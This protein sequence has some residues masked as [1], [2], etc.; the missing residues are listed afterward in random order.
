MD[1][2]QR[3]DLIEGRNAVNEAMRAGRAIDKLFVSRGSNDPALG[4]I[5]T[6]AKSL[7]RNELEKRWLEFYARVQITTWSD[8]RTDWFHEYAA[9]EWQGMLSDFY[10]PRWEAFV[11]MLEL[12]LYNGKPLPSYRFYDREIMFAY[13]R[14]SYPT[15]PSEDLKKTT[16]DFLAHCAR[17]EEKR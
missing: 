4:R 9:K 1:D 11:S 6:R 14:K 3:T 13:G 5:I 10:R 12:S 17:S 2:G 16:E 7:G 8:D 15:R